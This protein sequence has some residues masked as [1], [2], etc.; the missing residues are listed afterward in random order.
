MAVLKIWKIAMTGIQKKPQNKGGGL[1]FFRG[2]EENGGTGMGME[3]SPRR[4]SLAS[5]IES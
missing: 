5:Y 3:P 4:P 2:R 1:T